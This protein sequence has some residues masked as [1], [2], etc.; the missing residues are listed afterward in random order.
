MNKT[1]S[2]TPRRRSPWPRRLLWTV[3]V[4]MVLVALAAAVVVPRLLDVESYRAGLEAAIGEN[5][6]VRDVRIKHEGGPVLQID[7]GGSLHQHPDMGDQ[8]RALAKEHL[9]ENAVVR[10]TYRHE[11]LIR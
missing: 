4:G 5:N 2:T 3:L 9:G 8:L 11:T 1:P 6:R 7:L 10:V